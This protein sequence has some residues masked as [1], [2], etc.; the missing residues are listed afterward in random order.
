MAQQLENGQLTTDQATD[1]AREAALR[2]LTASAKSCHEL[3]AS[4]ARKGYP[5]HVVEAVIDRLNHVGL[6]NDRQYA[7][8]LVRARHEERG[9]ARRAI[10]MELSRR[11]IEADIAEAALREIDQASEAEAA[12][13]LAHKL[14]ARSRGMDSSVRIRRAASSLARKGY[15]P[16]VAF[17]FVKK[18]L[19]AEE[20]QANW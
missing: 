17:E 5:E 3:S 7:Q 13:L 9:L 15:S 18:A 10:A 19:A 1:L 11:G 8:N 16:T 2:S 12:Q 20:D 4:L 14:L 6:L